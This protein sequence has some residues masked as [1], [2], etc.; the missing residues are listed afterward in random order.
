MELDQW[1]MVYLAIA[2]SAA[3]KERCEWALFVGGLIAEAI[4]AIAVV[5]LVSIES[6]PPGSLPF[7]VG[8]G[9]IGVGI[10]SSLAWF[11]TRA[12]VRAEAVHLWSLM[13]GIEKEF[14]GAEFLR[15]LHRFSRGDPVCAPASNWTC[16]EWLPTV[17]RLPLAARLGP[18]FL[19]GTVPAVFLLGW[20]ALLVWA[21]AR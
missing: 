17:A 13:R 14:A 16:G 7:F 11:V 15:S 21:V 18:R 9:L 20:I 1:L 12:R 3:T 4:L 8:I 6:G 10:I 5:F 2:Q 19:A